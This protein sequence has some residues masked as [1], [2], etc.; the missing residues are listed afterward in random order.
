VSRASGFNPEAKYAVTMC[1]FSRLVRRTGDEAEYADWVKD[2]AEHG[3]HMAS[4][5]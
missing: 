4:E 5:S 3:V 1:E 2:I